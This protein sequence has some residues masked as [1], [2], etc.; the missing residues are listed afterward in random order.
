MKKVIALALVST[1]AF[2]FNAYATATP[3]INGVKTKSK[4]SVTLRIQETSLAKKKVQVRVYVEEINASDQFENHYSMKL[5]SSGKQD[6]KI[7]GLDSG[8]TYRF[9]VKIRRSRADA[10]SDWSSH[11]DVTT[12]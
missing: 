4:S 12:R 1:F 9:K 7:S 10:W 6:V 5:N 2:A 8:I 11:L 3:T